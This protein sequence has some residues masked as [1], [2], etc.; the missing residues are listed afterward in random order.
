MEIASSPLG[1][2]YSSL[3]ESGPVAPTD[4]TVDPGADCPSSGGHA[5][6]YP[7]LA[8]LGAPTF[9]NA[10]YGVDCTTC[11]V[12]VAIRTLS[13]AAVYGLIIARPVAVPPPVT[14]NW[15]TQV[16]PHLPVQA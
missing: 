14:F 6:W 5:C 12:G 9:T 7:R 13:T 2:I 11:E 15:L 3:Y 1:A 8:A 10:G 16:A 4:A